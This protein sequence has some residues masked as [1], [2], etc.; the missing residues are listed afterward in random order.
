[1]VSSDF[2]CTICSQLICISG[3]GAISLNKSLLCLLPTPA[4]FFIGFDAHRPN[5]ALGLSNNREGQ[6]PCFEEF[7]IE[8]HQGLEEAHVLWLIYSQRF[9]RGSLTR[10]NECA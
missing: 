3:F 2:A 10:H 1:M 7:H 8:H 9:T 5:E 4:H 6:V